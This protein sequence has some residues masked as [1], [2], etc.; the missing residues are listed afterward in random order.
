MF[1]LIIE[2][3]SLMVFFNYGTGILFLCNKLMQEIRVYWLI[4]THMNNKSNF[5]KFQKRIY[6]IRQ[7]LNMRSK[8]LY[9]GRYTD[10]QEDMPS[11]CLI[12]FSN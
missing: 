7:L 2:W 5:H 3:N 10:E 9:F 11:G 12:I 1:E 4:L 6:F 8:E